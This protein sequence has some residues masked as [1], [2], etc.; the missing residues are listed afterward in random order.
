MALSPWI[1]TPAEA[2][3]DQEEAALD[4]LLGR[5]L[6]WPETEPSDWN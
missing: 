2:A 1:D 5:F 6:D 4:D 3:P